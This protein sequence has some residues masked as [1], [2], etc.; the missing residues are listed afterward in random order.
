MQLAT[1]SRNARKVAA[2]SGL[3]CTVAEFEEVSAEMLG[4][5]LDLPLGTGFEHV[6]EWARLL[7]LVRPRGGGRWQLDPVVARLLQEPAAPVGR[8]NP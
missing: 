7:H 3:T 8:T 4:D 1:G 5:V 6:V 2:Y